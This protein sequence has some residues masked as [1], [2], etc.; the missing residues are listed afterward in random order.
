MYI[1]FRLDIVRPLIFLCRE[2]DATGLQQFEALIAITNIISVGLEEQERF[3]SAK[4]ISSVHY[5]MFSDTMMIRRVATEAICNICAHT[6]ALKLL[7]NPENL[8]L[9]IAFCVDWESDGEDVLL[10]L[11]KN[12]GNLSFAPHYYTAQAA[13]GT[14]AMV[15]DDLMVSEC[16]ISPAVDCMKGLKA[17]LNSRKHSLVLR[18]LVTINKMCG[19]HGFDDASLA[20]VVQQLQAGKKFNPSDMKQLEA[21]LVDWSEAKKTRLQVVRYFVENELIDSFSAV[22]SSGDGALG[23]LVNEIIANVSYVLEDEKQDM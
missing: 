14:L 8:K 7:R 9:W 22:L 5:L 18:A 21:V 6:E 10:E 4:G 3:V 16:M 23:S 13:A 20:D 12:V 11:E 17:L 1:L 19:S 15:C 2:R